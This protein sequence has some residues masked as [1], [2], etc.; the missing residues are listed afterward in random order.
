MNYFTSCLY[1]DYKKYSKIKSDLDLKKDDKLYILGD[2]LDG[3]DE[4]PSGALSIMDDII[5]SENVT[6]ILGD[7]ELT[8]A[9]A[10]LN[11]DD[12]EASA[13]FWEYATHFDVSGESFNEFVNENFTPEM[14]EKY[15]GELL[16]G[17]EITALEKIGNRY[18]YMCHGRPSAYREAVLEQWQ[19]CTTERNPDFHISPWRQIKTDEIC[20]QFASDPLPMEEKN[21]ITL[22]GQMSE[23]EACEIL[24]CEPTNTGIVFANK[25]LVFGRHFV[26]E[27]VN[28]IGIDAAGFFV[29]GRY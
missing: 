18:F 27:P 8:R 17:S 10:Y 28:V 3:N 14:S 2:I 20:A 6:L 13:T 26:D 9:Y 5:E 12:A 16:L 29:V 25:T 15:F 22:A 7:H 24:K 21:T 1:G 4:D 23:I 19:R 11:S